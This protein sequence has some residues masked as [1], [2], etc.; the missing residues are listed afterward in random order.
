MVL[1][2]T[3]GASGAAIDAV[4][5]SEIGLRLALDPE[6]RGKN[7][8]RA[9]NGSDADHRYGLAPHAETP[10]AR[11]LFLL[12]CT[13]GGILKEFRNLDPDDLTYFR[14]LGYRIVLE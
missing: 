6:I 7:R 1:N 13:L 8:Y 3:L 5:S 2:S 12:S 14:L 10:D 4:L 11:R 9:E